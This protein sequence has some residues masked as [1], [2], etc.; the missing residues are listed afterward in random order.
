[1][2]SEDT[3]WAKDVNGSNYLFGCASPFL[4][5]KKGAK[6][7]QTVKFKFTEISND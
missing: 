4:M 1:M 6:M 2:T 3:P 7:D 5:Y